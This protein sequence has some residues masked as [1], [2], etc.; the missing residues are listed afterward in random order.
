MVLA[1][2]HPLIIAFDCENSFHP[3]RA[4]QESLQFDS[5]EPIFSEL[6]ILSFQ[7][8][9]SKSYWC[10]IRLFSNQ[11]MISLFL[12]YLILTSIF[13]HFPILPGEL[14][15]CYFHFQFLRWFV[16]EFSSLVIIH[17]FI[18]SIPPVVPSIPSQACAI[19][20]LILS[21]RISSMPNPLLVINLI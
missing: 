9:L 5:P 14:C 15:L 17:S 10:I 6:F 21:T 7:L 4:I 8:S 16:Q 19:S 12:L 13:T 3:S 1:L 11:V 2:Y 18:V 20:L